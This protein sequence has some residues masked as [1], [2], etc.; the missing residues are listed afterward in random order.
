MGVTKNPSVLVMAKIAK[1][2]NIGLDDLLEQS[3]GQR[4]SQATNSKTR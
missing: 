3:Y 1:E 2:L 4:K